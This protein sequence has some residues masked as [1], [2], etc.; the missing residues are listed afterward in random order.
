M[1]KT[2]MDNESLQAMIDEFGD[3][4]CYIMFQDRFML[5]IGYK[6]SPLKHASDL[7]LR[8][9]NGIDMVGVPKPAMNPADREKGVAGVHWHRTGAIDMVGVMDEGCEKYRLDPYEL[10]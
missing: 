7:Q 3:R 2:N 6:S 9:F 8:T 5:F 1:A 10:G 4:I